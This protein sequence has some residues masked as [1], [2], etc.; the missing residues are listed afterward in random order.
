VRGAAVPSEE[1]G[2]WNGNKIR[3]S[4]EHC[5][6]LRRMTKMVENRVGADFP[7]KPLKTWKGGGEIPFRSIVRKKHL[8]VFHFLCRT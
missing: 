8:S 4:G 3:Q 7:Q 2:G 1:S 6:T 5:D